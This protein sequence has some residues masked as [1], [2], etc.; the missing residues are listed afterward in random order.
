[1]A[2]TDP[3]AQERKEGSVRRVSVILALCGLM[4][5]VAPGGAAVASDRTASRATIVQQP[6]PAQVNAQLDGVCAFPVTATDRGGL[7]LST[8][9]D[10]RGNIRWQELTG[11]TVIEFTHGLTK[12]TI[13]IEADVHTSFVPGPRGIW[14]EIQRGSWF[15]AMDDGRHTG[16]PSLTWFQGVVISRGVLDPK[17]LQMEVFSQTRVGHGDNICEML[18]TGL[19]PRH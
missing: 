17:T 2:E 3:P 4:A 1:M 15:V 13:P 18:A 12:T 5:L 14:T 16:I 11:D 19:K 8:A 7:T 9:Y 6:F 10:G